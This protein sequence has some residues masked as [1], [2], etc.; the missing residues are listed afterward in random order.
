MVVHRERSS[1][2]AK[3]STTSYFDQHS[4]QTAGQVAD[5]LIARGPRP[6]IADNVT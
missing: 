5:I 3:A 2:I 6:Q 1:S 4:R